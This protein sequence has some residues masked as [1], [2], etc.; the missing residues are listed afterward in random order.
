MRIFK[1]HQSD[2]KEMVLKLFN[3]G[4]HIELGCTD[5]KGTMVIC[6]ISFW[7]SIATSKGGT[8]SVLDR[9]GYGTESLEFDEHGAL[10]VVCDQERFKS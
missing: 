10:K 3:R 4:T 8:K 1:E 9:L 7:G 6:L 2:K 5:E